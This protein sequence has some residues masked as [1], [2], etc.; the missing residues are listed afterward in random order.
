MGFRNC[1]FSEKNP[2]PWIGIFKWSWIAN[3]RC[4]LCN[5]GAEN[6]AG[7]SWY[8]SNNPI[9]EQFWLNALYRS[10][11]G[12]LKG[13][14]RTKKLF[15]YLGENVGQNCFDNVVQVMLSSVSKQRYLE[16][17]TLAWWIES[18]LQENV[19]FIRCFLRMGLGRVIIDSK[20]DTKALKARARMS[21]RPFLALQVSSWLSHL[22]VVGH[23]IVVDHFCLCCQPPGCCRPP[24][25]FWPQP[26]WPQPF[27]RQLQPL[28]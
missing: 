14:F 23:V 17:A 28:W 2:F 7:S 26:F 11:Q 18:V 21:P 22:G 8:Y 19:L 6:C 24:W 10:C 3:G 13:N 9:I 20:V 16:N 27:W 1:P 4:I 25:S 5:N 15:W 12:A